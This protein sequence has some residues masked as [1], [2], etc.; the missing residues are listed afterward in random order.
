MS[1]PE[2]PKPKSPNPV[3]V[4]W[5]PPVSR[6]G[7]DVERWISIPAGPRDFWSFP[8]TRLVYCSWSASDFLKLVFVTHSFELKPILAEELGKKI[9]S[10]QT[11]L[12]IPENHQVPAC[13]ES[14]S[15]DRCESF[16][17]LEK[18]EPNP[19][20]ELLAENT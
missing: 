12:L 11:S 9:L 4:Y 18:F 6:A 14:I 16:M 17:R 3:S 8:S 19:V 20:Y 5:L 13:F 15:I 2:N 1:N 10:G 7:E